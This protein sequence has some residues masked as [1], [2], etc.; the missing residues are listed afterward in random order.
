[1]QLNRSSLAARQLYTQAVEANRIATMDMSDAARARRSLLAKRAYEARVNLEASR[2]TAAFALLAQVEAERAA[3][4][5][6][7]A[8][9]LPRDVANRLARE[10]YLEEANGAKLRQNSMLQAVAAAAR[11]L[12]AAP[13]LGSA[14]VGKSESNQQMSID[15]TNGWRPPAYV[16]RM[17]I[18]FPSDIR[19]AAGTLKGLEDHLCGEQWVGAYT[20]HMED[21][22]RRV[23]LEAERL[24]NEAASDVGSKTLADRASR[25]AA[26]FA[27]EDD[28]G[29]GPYNVTAVPP[30]PVSGITIAGFSLG[31][32]LAMGV[33]GYVVY[34]VIKE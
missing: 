32:L 30:T 24:A 27:T 21:G 23:A 5:E 28:T 26:E 12:Q 1:M 2:F 19:K 16:E 14:L 17:G 15:P 13:P 33:A 29:N 22:A 31:S 11:S 3:T 6:Q 9:A 7:R 20:E 34:R 8:R 18:F 10:T 25:M 4:A